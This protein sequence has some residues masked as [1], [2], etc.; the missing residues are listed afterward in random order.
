MNGELL[1]IDIE[2]TPEGHVAGL[3]V[4]PAQEERFELAWMARRRAR[5]ER[6][7]KPEPAYA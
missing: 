6:Y 2:P 7:A 5:G 1:E 3:H 4:H